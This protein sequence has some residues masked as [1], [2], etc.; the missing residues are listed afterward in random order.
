[1]RSRSELDYNSFKMLGGERGAQPSLVK[2]SDPRHIPA[3][4]RYSAGPHKTQLVAVNVKF[5]LRGKPATYSTQ[6]RAA[7]VD[8]KIQDG[9]FDE[10]K[11]CFGNDAE[12]CEKSYGL[13]YPMPGRSR[14]FHYR[15]V[16]HL[17]RRFIPYLR[18]LVNENKEK[19]IKG[20]WTKVS[21]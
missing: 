4:A 6:E 20:S 11:C 8:E 12:I 7:L 15:E 13:E 9:W 21:L 5:K 18:Y 10:M 16:H 2:Y 14:L 19:G 1:M 3:P 17:P